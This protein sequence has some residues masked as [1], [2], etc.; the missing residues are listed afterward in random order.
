M[1]IVYC[2]SCGSFGG[3]LI[4]ENNMFL[5]HCAWLS[6][7]HSKHCSVAAAATS[8][9]MPPLFV[10]TRSGA[11]ALAINHARMQ[12]TNWPARASLRCSGLRAC[13]MMFAA[14]SFVELRRYACAPYIE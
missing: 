12:A 5:C 3:V 13:I 7:K 4:T 6:Y 9:I 2:V 14:C 8:A 11:S 1:V 10:A